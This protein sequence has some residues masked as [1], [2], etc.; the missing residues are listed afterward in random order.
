MNHVL[1]GHLD[2]S[3]TSF[4]DLMVVSMIVEHLFK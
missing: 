3:I 4:D 1:V 2:Q